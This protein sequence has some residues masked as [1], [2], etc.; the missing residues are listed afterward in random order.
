MS[1]DNGHTGE[2]GCERHGSEES[3]WRRINDRY[4]IL[5]ITHLSDGIRSGYFQE[6]MAMI[7]LWKI[8]TR[9]KT[10]MIPMMMICPS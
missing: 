8:L 6:T 4:P 1:S 10:R 2:R 9:K 3:A 5:D 7:F